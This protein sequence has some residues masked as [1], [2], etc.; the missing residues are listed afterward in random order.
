VDVLLAEIVKNS[1]MTTSKMPKV[2]V[3]ILRFWPQFRFLAL[4]TD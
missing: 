4:F 1:E 2:T 3:T